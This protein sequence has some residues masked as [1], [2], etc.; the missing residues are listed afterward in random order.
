MSAVLAHDVSGVEELL[1]QW[2]D[3]TRSTAEQLGMPATSGIA[4]MIEMQKVFERRVKGRRR[5]P[6]KAV[7][8]V[9]PDGTAAQ[10]C[11]CGRIYIE[12]RCPRCNSDP[13]PSEAVVHG[14]ET[15]SFRPL[16]MKELSANTATIDVI[17]ASAP[18]WA[19]KCLR[20]SYL[21]RVRDSKAA[22]RLQIR[23]STY[24]EK[25]R[26]AVEYVAERLAERA[27]VSL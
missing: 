23:K 2:G 20:L 4:R 18:G 17:V 3:E 24:A 21:F 12:A 22:E 7:P 10:L 19:Q 1:Y 16:K 9:L 13:R 25:R 14:V 8:H 11:V 6:R 15:R 5:R 26:A 27:L